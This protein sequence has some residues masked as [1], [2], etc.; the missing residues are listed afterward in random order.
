MC[1]VAFVSKC[2][3]LPS[4]SVPPQTFVTCV[5]VGFDGGCY[6]SV[7]AISMF[8]LCQHLLSLTALMFTAVKTYYKPSGLTVW[9]T[10]GHCQ[11]SY[12]FRAHK[13]LAQKAHPPRTEVITIIQE[14]YC[15]RSVSS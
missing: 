3:A 7:N 14:A 2:L 13:L 10:N 12:T 8:S 5:I 1:P 9:T 15:R 6:L 4:N 11:L